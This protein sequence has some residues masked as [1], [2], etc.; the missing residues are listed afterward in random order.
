MEVNEMEIYTYVGHK[1][2]TRIILLKRA[3]KARP[4]GEHGLERE[5]TDVHM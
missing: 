5:H 2:V 1:Y 4:H 3:R